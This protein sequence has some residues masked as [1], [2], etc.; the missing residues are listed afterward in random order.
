MSG[1]AACKGKTNRSVGKNGTLVSFSYITYHAVDVCSCQVFAPS[2]IPWVDSTTPKDG[3][4]VG[5]EYLV[6]EDEV[7]MVPLEDKQ[8]FEGFH[9]THFVHL[10]CVDARS[11]LPREFCRS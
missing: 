11:K 4:P 8:G 9:S 3:V 2:P 1:G 6:A 7:V 5:L 10:C